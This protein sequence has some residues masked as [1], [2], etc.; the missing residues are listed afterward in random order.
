MYREVAS[1]FHLLTSPEEYA[2]E[3]EFYSRLLA[4]GAEIPVQSVLELGSGG[5]NNASHLKAR[6]E[7]TLVDLSD[8]MLELSKTINP[9]CEHVQ[10]DMRTL[11]LGRSFDAV[12]VH[13]AVVYMTSKRDL[14]AAMDTAFEH[15]RPGGA[16]LFAPD[17]VKETLTMTTDHGGNDGDTRSLRYLEW[18][19]DPDPDDDTYLTDYAFLL[20]D[21]DGTV[22]VELDRHT[23]GVF[24]RET[25]IRSLEGAGF[26]VERHDGIEDETGP[27]MFV[28]VRPSSGV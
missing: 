1:W 8:E 18:V 15:C 3:A 11:R 4:R 10:G 17:N 14:R 12:F 7:M 25:W 27:D 2:V 21:E 9:E 5:G 23:C 16:A 13:D 28:G 24:S 26:R 22:R 6:F 19:W 20:R